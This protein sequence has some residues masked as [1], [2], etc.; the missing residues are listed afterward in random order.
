MSASANSSLNPVGLG[1]P[2]LLGVLVEELTRRVLRLLETLEVRAA[3]DRDAVRRPQCVIQHGVEVDVGEVDALFG[4]VVDPLA[5]QV[6]V[7]IHL[8]QADRVRVVVALLDRRHRPDVGLIA[9]RGQCPDRHLDGL[10]EVRRVHRLGDV[11]RAEVARNVLAHLGVGQILVEHRRR[12]HLQDLR[13]QVAMGDLALD[14][15]GTVH[16]VLVHDVRVTRLELQLGQRL[17]EL[18]RLD[19]RLADPR[20]VDHLV[21]LLGHR[22]VGERP[23]RRHARRR[24]ARTGTCPRCFLA[25]SNVMSGNHHTEAQ[26]LDADLLV[27]VLALGVQEAVDVGVMRVQVH[28]TGTLPCTELIGVG[29][30]VLQQLHDRNDTRALVLDVLDRRAVL[31]NV[32]QQQGNTAAALGQLQRRVDRAPDGLHVV[33][34]A[35][36]EAAHRLAALLLA[37]VQERR[38]GRLEAAVDDLV[39]E[40]LGQRRVTGGQRQRH[41]DDAVLEALQIALAVKGL[42]RVAGVVLERAEERRE[43]EL[44]GIC[45]VQQRLDE[46]ARVLVEHLA[47]VVVLLDQVVELLVLSRGRTPCSG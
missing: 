37:R 40:L 15:V 29:E 39:D 42:Q 5:R 19:L 18:A 34:D 45:A 43:P 33:L 32:G 13:A 38:G 21:V 41:H 36:Q 10:R 2:H 47:L 1:F 20:V 28:R 12:G 3:L 6:A 7:Q 24:T 22:D 23:R 31:T 30:R 25:S 14:R 16:R 27:G 44:L 4:A 35:Q 11:Q 46:V 26:R 17:E 8:P 9:H